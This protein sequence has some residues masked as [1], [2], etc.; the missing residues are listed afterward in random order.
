[1][2]PLNIHYVL[3]SLLGPSQVLSHF[4]FTTALL[5]YLASNHKK[6]IIIFTL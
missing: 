5:I 1:M 6:I 2:C 3:N 4:I